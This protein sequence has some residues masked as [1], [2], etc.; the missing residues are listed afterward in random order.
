MPTHSALVLADSDV[1]DD[2]EEDLTDVDVSVV[3]LVVAAL[4]I[5][6]RAVIRSIDS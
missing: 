6:T 5:L 3:V 4:E 1:A 2:D